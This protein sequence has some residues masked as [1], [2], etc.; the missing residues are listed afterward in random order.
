MDQVPLSGAN[1]L[2]R[3]LQLTQAQQ[4]WCR[5]TRVPVTFKVAS[6]HSVDQD[7]VRVDQDEV[8][9]DQDQVRV[10]QDQVRVD[11]VRV[12]QVRM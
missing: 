2:G 9:V 1:E 5:G 4:P 12:D 7:Q 6:A 3:G 8:R 10:D 11:Q